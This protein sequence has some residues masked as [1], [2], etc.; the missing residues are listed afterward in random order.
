MK[1]KCD[2]LATSI[3]SAQSLSEPVQ[4]P[5]VNQ[6][7]ESN[8]SISLQHRAVLRQTPSSILNSTH[9]FHAQDPISVAQPDHSN[10]S[11]QSPRSAKVT[12]LDSRSSPSISTSDPATW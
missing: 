10:D 9:L 7:S 5:A 3:A 4:D 2:P 1:R 12:L 6:T 8:T 11:V